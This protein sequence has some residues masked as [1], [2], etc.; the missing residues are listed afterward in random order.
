VHRGV[1]N[2]AH[3]RDA[4]R[5]GFSNIVCEVEVAGS[6]I[7]RALNAGTAEWPA[8]SGRFPYVS[9]LT[10]VLDGK[11]PAGD[12]IVDVRIGGEPVTLGKRYKLAI[13]DYLLNGG[14][15]YDM[16]LGQRVLVGSENGT[17]IVSALEKAVAAQP[18]IAPRTD[19]R[20]TIR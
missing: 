11:R 12:R 4:A 1:H 2:S 13:P 10:F 15:G 16:F 8:A 7:V 14:D 18:A 20:I 19:G 5:A 3:R 9:G 6:I 17:L